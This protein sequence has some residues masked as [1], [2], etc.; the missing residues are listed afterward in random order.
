MTSDCYSNEEFF[1]L[2]YDSNSSGVKRG[3]FTTYIDIE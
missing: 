2:A 1:N 3:T